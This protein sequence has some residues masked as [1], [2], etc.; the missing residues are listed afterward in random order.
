[1][2]AG[3]L[4][5]LTA[6]PGLGLRGRLKF[7]ERR[8]LGPVHEPIRLVIRLRTFPGQPFDH[9]AAINGVVNGAFEIDIVLRHNSPTSQT[10]Y[11]ERRRPRG[12]SI[13]WR[14]HT[15]LYPLGQAH[16]DTY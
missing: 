7:P 9:L 13:N 11:R 16:R 3:A 14:L 2:E 10:L 4:P 15:R 8:P 12:Q 6:L 1:M 5:E